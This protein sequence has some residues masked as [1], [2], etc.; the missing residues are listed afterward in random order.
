MNSPN[1]F[2]DI[3][4]FNSTFLFWF[5]EMDLLKMALVILSD[6]DAVSP[7]FLEESFWTQD[8]FKWKYVVSGF[9]VNLRL[10]ESLW[11]IRSDF[12]STQ[13]NVAGFGWYR[14]T[15]GSPKLVLAA[16]TRS[17]FRPKK[18]CNFKLA[19][20]LELVL[21]IRSFEEF[22]TSLLR[23][24]IGSIPLGTCFLSCFLGY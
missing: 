8:F 22:N 21:C 2:L 6:S 5:V 7:N 15:R 4:N 10:V 3:W 24:A 1:I 16:I 18:P 23:F 19:L 13:N 11:D 20:P 17:N 9:T 12:F 14:V